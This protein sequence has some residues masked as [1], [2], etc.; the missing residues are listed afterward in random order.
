MPRQRATIPS[1]LY[2]VAWCSATVI[3]T[4][5]EIEHG[6]ENGVAIRDIDDRA[7]EEDRLHGFVQIS[8]FLGSVEVGA[9]EE[10]AA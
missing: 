2:P 8:L 4:V 10:S 1:F 5:V 7:F 9:D 3:L 6:V